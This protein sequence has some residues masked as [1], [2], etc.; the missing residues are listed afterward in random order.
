[1]SL[2]S[3]RERGYNRG[4]DVS[5]L[6]VGDRVVVRGYGLRRVSAVDGSR[7]AVSEDEVTTEVDA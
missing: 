7:C 6:K 2:P 3:R 4:M 1:M 5:E